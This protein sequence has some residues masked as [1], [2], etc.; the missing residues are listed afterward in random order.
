MLASDSGVVGESRLEFEAEEELIS[1]EL[2]SRLSDW[3]FSSWSTSSSDLSKYS[4]DQFIPSVEYMVYGT[5]A[6]E[7]ACLS[8][9]A[10]LLSC[11]QS[12]PGAD[13]SH[14]F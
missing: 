14:T 12:L 2:E 1:S 9:V 6:S 8:W 5:P 7:T 3:E 4:S 13:W 11:A 10:W